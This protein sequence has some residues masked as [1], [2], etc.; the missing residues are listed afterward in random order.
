MTDAFHAWLKQEKF[1]VTKVIVMG[2]S[3]EEV[4]AA[5]KKIQDLQPQCRVLATHHGY[6]DVARLVD[7]VAGQER[8]DVILVG[9]GSPKSEHLIQRLKADNSAP[10]IWHV[11]GGSL[12]FLAGTDVE[13]PGWMRKSG[14]QWF[15]RL[16]RNP[17]KMA[18]RYLWGNPLFV[19]RIF[20]RWAFPFRRKD[21]L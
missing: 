5:G 15:H 13:A 2:C 11:G 12:K 8:A 19:L 9:M 20:G 14:L 21:N 16:W 6:E 18:G 4:V 17:R 3:E 1:Q 10:V 7:W